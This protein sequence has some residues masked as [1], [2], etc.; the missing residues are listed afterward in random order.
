MNRE[1]LLIEGG[2]CASKTEMYIDALQ[3]CPQELQK[4]YTFLIVK[5]IVT[6]AISYWAR[7]RNGATLFSNTLLE[8]E[9]V[10]NWVLN[11]IVSRGYMVY[12][13][14]S[15]YRLLLHEYGKILLSL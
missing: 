8:Y 4:S 5:T 14:P 9:E 13:D 1:T 7:T 12:P 2:K 15:Q 6:E 10:Y 11:D 3:V